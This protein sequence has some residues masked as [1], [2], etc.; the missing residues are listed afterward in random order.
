M[1]QIVSKKHCVTHELQRT[2][3]SFT[4]KGT[5][6]YNSKRKRCCMNG[7]KNWK[8]LSGEN[9]L[10]GKPVH[11]SVKNT[12]NN[13]DTWGFI[14][15]FFQHLYRTANSIVHLVVWVKTTQILRYRQQHISQRRIQHS[16]AVLMDTSW[17]KSRQHKFLDIGNSIFLQERSITA[18]KFSE[19]FTT[20]SLFSLNCREQQGFKT[21]TSCENSQDN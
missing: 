13:A 20:Y 1:V 5:G 3:M 7:K 4:K 21:S 9:Y 10:L 16:R 14:P 6:T 11:F 8:S 12:A 15:L 2:D 17:L 19:G 18:A